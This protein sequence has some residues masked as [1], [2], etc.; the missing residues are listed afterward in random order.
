VYTT[1]GFEAL[2]QVFSQIADG[3]VAGDE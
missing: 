1:L 2:E 3:E